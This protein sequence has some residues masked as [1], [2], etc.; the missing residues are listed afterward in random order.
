MACVAAAGDAGEE[1]R[2]QTDRRRPTR[3]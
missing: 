1:H 2:R 3:A